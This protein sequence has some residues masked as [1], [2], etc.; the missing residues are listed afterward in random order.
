[1]IE[2]KPDECRV[3]GVLIEKA[4]TT[5]AQ[6]PL[7]L[8]AVVTGCNQ[9]NNRQPITE[10]DEDRTLRALDHLRGKGLIVETNM[11]G[12]RVLKYRH[13]AREVLDLRTPALVILAELLLRGPQTVGEL[14]SRASRMHPFESIE[15]VKATLDTMREGDEPMVR[16]LPGGRAVRYA[17]L[18]C[19]DLHPLD[20]ADSDDGGASVSTGSETPL[21]LTRLES[22]VEDLEQQ[23]ATT[24]SELTQLR[25]YLTKLADSL[26]E[27][28]PT[29]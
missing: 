8:N 10:F 4:Q 3:L 14:R 21:R 18:L 23:L 7:S 27:P 6:Y 9:K 12:S 22:Q 15:A 5:P 26:G 2:L 24:R 1:M 13:E 29:Q 16:M 28:G 11:M 19:P 17:Q 25:A 20:T